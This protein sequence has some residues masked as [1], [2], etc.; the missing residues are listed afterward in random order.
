MMTRTRPT[1]TRGG[2]ARRQA[3]R[4]RLVLLL[5]GVGVVLLAVAV[6]ALS[7][8]EAE[9][10]VAVEDLAGAPAILGDDLPP[11]PAAPA[12]DPQLG[13]SAPVVNGTD[14]DGAPVQ[15]GGSGRGQLLVFVASWCP[16]C[17]QELPEVV[18]WLEAGRLPEG[19]EFTTVVTGLDD[20][21]PNWPPTAWLEAEGYDGRVLMDD[22]DGLVARSFGMPGTPYWVA[23]DADGRVVHRSAGLLPQEEMDRLAALVAS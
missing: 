23:L 16:A 19:V 15:I 5:A 14:A 10:V 13:A 6:A 3:T 17:Q 2:H 21:R 4:R 22:A 11:P 1:P 8:G 7:T 12:D 9:E 18:A 20:N